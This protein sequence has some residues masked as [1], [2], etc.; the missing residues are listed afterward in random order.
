MEVGLELVQQLRLE[1]QPAQVEPVDGVALEHLHDRTREVPT[2]VAE[3]P[4][5]RRRRLGQ[6]RPLAPLPRPD[7]AVRS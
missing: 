3:P 6:A 7:G 2:D 5:N 1:Q 4:G